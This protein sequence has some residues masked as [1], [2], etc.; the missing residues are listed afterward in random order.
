MVLE[1]EL[2][3]VADKIATAT[4][5]VDILGP[6][7]SDRKA[8]E[9]AMD[10]LLHPDRWNA[11]PPARKAAEKAF[12]RLQELLALESKAAS[13]SFDVVTKTRT[14][15]VKNLAFAGTVSNLYT[16]TYSRDGKLKTGLLKLPRSVRDNDL[17]AAESDALKTIWKSGK[18]RAAY[19]PRWEESF[20]H[21]DKSTGVDRRALVIR[22]LDGFVSLADVKA[23]YPDGLDARDLAWIW[24]RALAG[25]SLLGELDIVHG[26]IGPE[27][28]LIHPQ[29]HGVQFCGF[30]ATVPVGERVKIMGTNR[31]LAAPEIIAKQQVD[32]TTDIYMLHKTMGLMLRNDQPLQFRSFIKGVTF[33][34]QAVRP[35]DCRA[36]LGEYDSLLARLYGARKFRVF[37]PLPA[38]TA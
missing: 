11:H 31:W 6:A 4:S 33:D 5:V 14:Y 2:R 35:K 25:L 37:P 10:K 8:R 26:A 19:F 7:D 21:R 22:R 16:C 38:V 18:K 29:E 1:E 9:R 30:S 15:M 32:H 24:R 13:P 36:L 20:K 3:R 17:V 27:H 12:A 34:R 28:V 23:A